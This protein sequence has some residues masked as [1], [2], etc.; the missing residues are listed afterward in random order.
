VIALTGTASIASAADYD[1]SVSRGTYG[2]EYR[3]RG[4][5]PRFSRHYRDMYDLDV[6]YVATAPEVFVE[7][8]RPAIVER[9]T[10]VERPVVVE[11]RVIVERPVIERRVVVERPAVIER[12]SVVVE[13]VPP[14][15]VIPGPYCGYC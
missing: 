12:R 5:G 9:R 10:I 15:D 13:Q 14:V 1:L 3:W 4:Y 2:D 6:G 7:R 8:R 11:K